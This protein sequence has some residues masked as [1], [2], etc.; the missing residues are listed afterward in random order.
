MTSTVV[1]IGAAEA[2]TASPSASSP[3]ARHADPGG[4]RG[5]P[6]RKVTATS[7]GSSA[8]ITSAP[9]R[10]EASAP[11]TGTDSAYTVAPS[12]RGQRRLVTSRPA[13]SAR[14]HASGSS[15]NTARRC[16]SHGL[17]PMSS[18]NRPRNACAGDGNAAEASG[19]P[20]HGA[21]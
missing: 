21:V 3:A 11:S 15:P 10:P 8:A 2:H 6:A 9:K 14:N 19:S 18:E 13:R 16:A 12:T 20:S 1:S 4:V 5:S 7:P 17:D